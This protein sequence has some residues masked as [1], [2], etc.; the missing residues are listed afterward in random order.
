MKD[1]TD[2]LDAVAMAASLT[3]FHVDVIEG[4]LGMEVSN[5]S[6]PIEGVPKV[7][8]PHVIYEHG[9]LMR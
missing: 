3:G 6:I 4:V 5:R 8:S 7:W 9:K 2:K 1:R